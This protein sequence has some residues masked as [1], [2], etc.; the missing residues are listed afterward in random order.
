MGRSVLKPCL[1]RG[2]P[3]VTE[4]S[5]C[6]VHRLRPQR[7]AQ[8]P[9]PH[10]ERKRRRLLREEHVARHGLVCPGYA[11]P[12]HRVASIRELSA[13]H[14]TPTSMG[15]PMDGPLRVLCARCNAGRGGANRIPRRR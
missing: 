12:P 1:V 6:S 10:A 11:R 15:G 14:I 7:K 5:R 9:I 3:R 2:C 4:G 8:A 13:D